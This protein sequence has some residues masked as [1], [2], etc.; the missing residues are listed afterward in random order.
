MQLGA[1]SAAFLDWPWEKVASYY[2]RLGLSCIEPGAGGFFPKNHCNPGELLGAP[3]KL[4]KFRG[5]LEKNELRLSAL[6]I[7][8][9]TLHPN[10]QIA[11]RNEQD[12]IDACKF[13]E[14]IGVCDRLTLLSGLPEGRPGDQMPNWF[15]FPMPGTEFIQMYEWQWEKRLIPGW[16]KLGKIAEDHGVRLC[17]EMCPVQAVYNPQTLMR[18]REAV[19]PVIGCN[20]DPSHLYH[21]NID[22][23]ELIETLGEA[24]YHVHAKDAQINPRIM[25]LNG[26]MD[27]NKI[28]EPLKRSWYYRAI[29]Y[30]HG[31]EYWR[32]FVSRLRMIGYDDVVSIEH[33]DR[34]MDNQEGFEKSVATMQEVMFA[35]PPAKLWDADM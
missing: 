35:K 7:H 12:L 2:K 1:V 18:L 6:A 17:F 14:K 32:E 31:A 23:I 5:I 8:G 13:C 4:K 11:A 22:T 20:Y 30:G 15:P 27:M 25:R 34:L 26:C 19:G 28:Q 10:K 33:E 21:L 9:E 29:G 24:I 3:A 16:R